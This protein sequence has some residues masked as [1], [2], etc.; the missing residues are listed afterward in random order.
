MLD[1]MPPIKSLVPQGSERQGVEAGFTLI[2]LLIVLVTLSILMSMVVFAVQDF[3]ASSAKAACESDLQTVDH[4]IEV[5][6]LQTGKMPAD[7]ADLMPTT[8]V[9][10]VNGEPVGPWLHNAPSDND[11]Y[12]IVLTNGATTYSVSGATVPAAGY[13]VVETYSG[14]AFAKAPKG[15]I[16]APAGGVVGGVA[17]VSSAC[18]FITG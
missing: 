10:S 16:Y 1:Q 3:S 12:Q 17:S 11:H 13:P 9:S 15:A 4:A 2:E 8:P 14:D 7:I 6:S 18:S 5:Y